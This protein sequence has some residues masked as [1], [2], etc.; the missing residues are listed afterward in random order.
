[1]KLMLNFKKIQKQD[2]D[3]VT[4]FGRFGLSSGM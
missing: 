4:L 1:M 2:I 3:V